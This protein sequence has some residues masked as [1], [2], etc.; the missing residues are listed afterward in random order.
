MEQLGKMGGSRRHFD[1][2]LRPLLPV[3]VSKPR[4]TALMAL[5]SFSCISARRR[6]KAGRQ[7]FYG[8]GWAGRVPVGH[9]AAQYNPNYNTQ[10]PQY[11]APPPN[12]NQT[13]DS[14]ANQSYFG[15]Q[16][17]VEM[18]PPQNVY[19]GGENGFQPPAGPPPGK[20]V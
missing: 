3:Q 13:T 14:G 7:P 15:G 18:Q 2:I 5:T 16:R 6:R 9:G 10:Q 20:I 8:T 19:Q 17:D 1:R 11:N 12:Y 4:P